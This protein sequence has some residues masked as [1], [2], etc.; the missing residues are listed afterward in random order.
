MRKNAVLSDVQESDNF[1]LHDACTSRQ[2]TLSHLVY[3]H[4]TSP[5]CASR[6][7]SFLFAFSIIAKPPK[8]IFLVLDGLELWDVQPASH[9]PS[10]FVFSA[11]KMPSAPGSNETKI[12]GTGLKWTDSVI[13]GQIKLLPYFPCLEPI[14]VMSW[15]RLIDP[16]GPQEPLQEMQDF[17]PGMMQD[18]SSSRAVAHTAGGHC[19]ATRSHSVR[20]N[21]PLSSG[22]SNLFSTDLKI[23]CKAVSW[24]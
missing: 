20:N 21:N 4:L 11:I 17:K 15:L 10:V 12:R 8:Q 19:T 1:K 23:M 14:T 6:C 3:W 18:P 2:K 22:L 7:S 13:V 9:I 16:H 24:M 5:A